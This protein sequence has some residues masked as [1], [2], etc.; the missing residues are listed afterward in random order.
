MMMAFED[1]RD[2][3]SDAGDLFGRALA[4]PGSGQRETGSA[5]RVFDAV[6]VL[7]TCRF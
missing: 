6:V 2:T 5:L 7:M 3:G 1:E 4:W